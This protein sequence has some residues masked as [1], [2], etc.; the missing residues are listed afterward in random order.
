MIATKVYNALIAAAI[1]ANGSIFGDGLKVKLV[2]NSFVPSPDLVLADLTF[3]A[4]T[5]S[6][7]KVITAADQ[8]VVRNQETGGY[9]IQMKEP[10]GGLN[11]ICSAAPSEPETIYGYV[12]TDSTDALICSALLEQQTI[13]AQV[14]DFVETPSTIGYFSAGVFES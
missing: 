4:F 14:G 7:P 13:I 1:A 6:T 2:K 8:S 5:G 9:G 12:V 11:F 10:A 3:A